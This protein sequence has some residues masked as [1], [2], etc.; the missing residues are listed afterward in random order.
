V[1]RTREVLREHGD[2]L[3]EL[4]GTSVLTFAQVLGCHSS[5]VVL[6]PDGCRSARRVYL[7][8]KQGMPHRR[9]PETG[10]VRFHPGLVRQWL[11][12]NE[13][14]MPAKVGGVESHHL[15]RGIAQGMREGLLAPEDV[16]M[17]VKVF[18]EREQ[19]ELYRRGSHFSLREV[20]DGASPLAREPLREGTAAL[21]R[22]HEAAVGMREAWTPNCGYAGAY[23]CDAE[24]ARRVAG[25]LQNVLEGLQEAAMSL[26]MAVESLEKLE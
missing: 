25:D 24:S 6:A 15:A 14:S 13:V 3:R 1:E 2:G 4:E 8:W 10:T 26:Q 21:T 9:D 5:D 12:D 18:V 11:Q 20:G 23:P 22:V 19:A 7:W 16:E 17:L